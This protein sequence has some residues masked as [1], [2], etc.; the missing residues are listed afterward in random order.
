MNDEVE[1]MLESN[2]KNTVESEHT[3]V[4]DPYMFILSTHGLP[5][6][7]FRQSKISRQVVG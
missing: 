4:T 1:I 2:K 7:F 6:T 3:N 5:Q